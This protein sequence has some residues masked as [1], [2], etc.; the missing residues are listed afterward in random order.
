MNAWTL[1][2]LSVPGFA[3]LSMVMERH[4]EDVSNAVPSAAQRLRAR[5]LGA[6]CLVAALLVSL[7][8]WNTSV[9]V[10]AWLGA[11]TFAALAVVGVLTYA[12]HRLRSVAVVAT[13]SGLLLAL[14]NW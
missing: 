4:A 1:W 5:V 14:V 11:L 8:H 6:V 12:P 7:H 10:V 9:A 13:C 3:A 2:L